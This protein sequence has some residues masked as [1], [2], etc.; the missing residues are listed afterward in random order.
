MPSS[1]GGPAN[2]TEAR[3]DFSKVKFEFDSFFVRHFVVK[4]Y[5]SVP[6]WQCV[7]H[8]TLKSFLRHIT[9]NNKREIVTTFQ[10]CMLYARG[11]KGL[12]IMVN[13]VG[14]FDKKEV[15]SW[16]VCEEGLGYTFLS[17]LSGQS[18]WWS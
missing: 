15:F 1:G 7:L 17:N 10:V 14:G 12:V 13:Y 16:D 11:G 4:C 6:R 8:I 2:G 5:A 3:P 9:M 18:K